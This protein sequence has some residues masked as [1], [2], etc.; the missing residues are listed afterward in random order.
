[1]G[2]NHQRIKELLEEQYQ[3]AQA[4]P[5]AA[6]LI[7]QDKSFDQ[8]N[9]EGLE[10]FEDQ[11]FAHLERSETFKWMKNTGQIS[12]DNANTMNWVILAEGA[13]LL[14]E[15]DPNFL[16]KADQNTLK[17]LSE[18]AQD[19]INEQLETIDSARVQRVG[20][21]C[22]LYTSPSPRDRQKSRMPSSA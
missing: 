14:N 17:L 22:L 21:T 13:R 15:I 7:P 5:D 19:D 11:I 1:M 16:S 10:N 12:D 4:N 3:E 9:F 20:E 18:T 2:D 6:S 8:A